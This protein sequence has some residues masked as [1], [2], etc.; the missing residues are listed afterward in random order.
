MQGNDV[1]S[2]IGDNGADLNTVQYG[3]GSGNGNGARS[4]SGDGTIVS[5]GEKSL[6]K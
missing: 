6:Y 4:G 5:P 1:G 2:G 3:G